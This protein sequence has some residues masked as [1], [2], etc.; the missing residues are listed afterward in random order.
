MKIVVMG[1]IKKPILLDTTEASA[2]FI[3]NDKDEP[4][5]IY[6]FP[7][8]SDSWVRYTKGE[9]ENFDDVARQLLPN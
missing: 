5:V 7:I 4:N 1:N 2:L 3:F 6:R 9:D 8:N